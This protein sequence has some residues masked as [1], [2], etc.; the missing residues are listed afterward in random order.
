METIYPDMEP[1]RYERNQ[2]IADR[3][4]LC[5]EKAERL[6]AQRELAERYALSIKTIRG[7]AGIFAR[8]TPWH[9]ILTD[10][11]NT[12][13]LAVVMT[14]KGFEHACVTCMRRYSGTI[15]GLELPQWR[16]EDQAGRNSILLRELRQQN[17]RGK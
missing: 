5:T 16:F 11:A 2:K 1:T 6:K 8:A 17:K 13:P 7:I 9:V 12:I 15:G 10:G 3:L 14:H 4:K